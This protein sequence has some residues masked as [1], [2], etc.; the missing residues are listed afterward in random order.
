MI[1]ALLLLNV[2]LGASEAAAVKMSRAAAKSILLCAT[3]RDVAS[4][5][6]AH[7]LI[8]RSAY[9]KEIT[10][11]VWRA[12]GAACS[13]VYL[14]L[15]QESLLQLDHCDRLFRE[16]AGID[17]PIDEVLFLSKHAAASGKPS[18][19]VHP[20]GI[21][22]QTEN[23][24][25]GGIP[26]R[27]SPPSS[28]IGAI[29]RELY[30]RVGAAGAYPGV[31][32]FEVTLEATHHGPHVDLPTAFLE[33]GST[34]DY[35]G[36]PD[37]GRLWGDLLQSHLGLVEGGAPAPPP[38]DEAGLESGLHAATAG[39]TVMGI[40]GGHYTP[41]MNDIARSAGRGLYIGH[42]LATYALAGHMDGSAPTQVPGGWRQIIRY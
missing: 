24:R 31:K 42:T 37:A 38:E 21:A 26:G 41:G 39:I 2:F 23:E 22:Y 8:Q 4:T 11:G 25:S 34:E 28:R 40:G 19:T 1:I 18:L 29:Y 32:G 10:A 36:N 30:D 35:W 15:Q 14:W 7:N 13:S 12:Q 16:H 33:I 6:I 3:T 27:C 20:I 17:K 5:N 9:F